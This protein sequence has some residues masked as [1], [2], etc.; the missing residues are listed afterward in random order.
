MNI[1]IAVRSN[2]TPHVHPAKCLGAI[3][4]SEVKYIGFDLKIK[5]GVLPK[6]LFQNSSSLS[7]QCGLYDKNIIYELYKINV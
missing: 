7:I 5:F 1:S 6:P 2:Y 3:D 4:A